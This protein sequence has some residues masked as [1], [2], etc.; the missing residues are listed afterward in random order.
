MKHKAFDLL[1]L[2]VVLGGGVLAW[3]TGRERSRL[4][5]NYQRLVRKTG[6]LAIKDASRVYLRSIETG[7]A[8]HFAWRVYFPRNYK[9]VLRLS[10]G[11]VSTSWSSASSEFIARV[12]FRQDEQGVLQVYTHFSSGSDR[13]SLGDKTL[14]ELLRDRWDK[15]K[16]EQLE[17]A[18]LAATGPDQSA[19]LLRLTLL[20]DLQ[21]EAR[22]KLS[23]DAL[24]HC[25]PVLFE[26]D[27]GPEA[28]NP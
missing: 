6:D 14:T 24:R 4:E 8:L 16:V 3:Q 2:I 22:K 1:L 23:P 7:E 13:M 20:D 17:E 10:S 5:G 25:L 28:S 12:R 18:D 27:L 19:V 15:I 11:G 9:Q 26:L 21:P